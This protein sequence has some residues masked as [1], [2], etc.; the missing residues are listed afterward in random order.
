MGLEEVE[1]RGSTGWRKAESS[2][3]V[4]LVSLGMETE[5]V[6]KIQICLLQVW[7]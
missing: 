2:T 4:Y 1:L 7:G 3:S 5:N 6:E